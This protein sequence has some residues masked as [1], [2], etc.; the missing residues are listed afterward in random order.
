LD[1]VLP[2]DRKLLFARAAVLDAARVKP[3]SRSDRASEEWMKEIEEVVSAFIDQIKVQAEL[4][5]A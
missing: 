3:E 5:E 2:T 1:Q 4:V